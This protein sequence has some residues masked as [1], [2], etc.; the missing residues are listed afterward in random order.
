MRKQA[1]ASTHESLPVLRSVS[2]LLSGSRENADSLQPSSTKGDEGN[3]YLGPRSLTTL[4]GS[5]LLAILLV[6]LDASILAT[7]IPQIT[8]HFHTIAG[9]GWYPAA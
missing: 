8:N 2:T 5:L 4:D 9:T 3:Q 6:T 7:A 1:A